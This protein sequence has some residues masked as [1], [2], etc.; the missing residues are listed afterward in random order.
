MPLMFG[1]YQCSGI[2]TK[3]NSAFTNKNW[4]PKIVKS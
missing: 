1:C 4:S 3:L 2:L